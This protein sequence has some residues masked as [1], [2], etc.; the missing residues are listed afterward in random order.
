MSAR[1]TADQI[2]TMRR[3]SRFYTRQL[4]LLVEGFLKSEFSLT[5]G[6]V[7]Y[8]LAH[9]DGLTAADLARELGL[10][11]GY[12]SRIL[13]RFEA[14]GFLGRA[15]AAGDGRQAVLAMTDEGRAA[16]QPLDQASEAE[17]AT[18]LAGL[19]EAERRQLVAAM[20]T[21]ERLLG[22]RT[23]PRVPYLLRPLQTG[24][25]GWIIRRQGMLY[26]EEFGWDETFE[27]LVA[28]IAAAFV[29]NHDPRTERCWIAEREGEIVGSVFVV[30]QSDAV[31]K[32][33][34]LYVEPSARGLGIGRRLVDESIRFARARHYQTLTLWTNDILASARRIYEEAGFRLVQ[35][36]RHHSFGKDLVGQ[37]WDLELRNGNIRA[38]NSEASQT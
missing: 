35:E 31:A 28:E 6:R 27:A 16:F 8:E 14:R 20:S 12:L 32:L 10:D 17:V 9:R 38:L 37:N 33:R 3:F 29:K 19:S 34:L 24:D 15:T 21:V 23:E 4:G 13:K 25:I 5:E 7:L 26:A 2:A 1:P 11:A 36:E 18:L 30:R 22:G